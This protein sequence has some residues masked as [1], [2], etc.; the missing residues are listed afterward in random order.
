M[1]LKEF[2]KAKSFANY[3]ADQI[4]QIDS[5]ELVLPINYDGF[6]QHHELGTVI[7][8]SKI[9]NP[10]FLIEESKFFFSEIQSVDYDIDGCKREFVIHTNSENHFCYE[11]FWLD[12][13]KMIE[14]AFGYPDDDENDLIKVIFNR[15]NSF[16]LK[17]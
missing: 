3:T 12:E 15:A 6:Y 14:F 10:Y 5:C 9:E 8:I 16:L 17:R 13:V 4:M 2:G 7:F 11:T 1:I